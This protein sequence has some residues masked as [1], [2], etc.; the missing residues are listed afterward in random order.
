MGIN[1][2]QVKAKIKK[3]RIEISMLNNRMEVLK[4]ELKNIK[5]KLRKT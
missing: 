1:D 3:R 2:D 5:E 4:E